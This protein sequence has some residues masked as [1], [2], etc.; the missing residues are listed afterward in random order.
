[1]VF[2]LSLSGKKSLPVSK[3]LL[4]NI[5][6]FNYAVVWMAS[7]RFPNS[8]STNPQTKHMRI[9]PSTTIIITIIIIIIYSLEFF[10]S[11]LADGLSLGIEWQQVSLSVQ[12]SS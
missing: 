1:M 3:T 2:L 5:A 6:D 9:V 4:C 7:A 8:N 11:A 12:D 10:A